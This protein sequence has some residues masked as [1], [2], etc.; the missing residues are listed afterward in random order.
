MLSSSSSSSPTS[1]RVWGI[2]HASA[3]VPVPK[4]ECFNH[5]GGTPHPS[6]QAFPAEAE[7]QECNPPGRAASEM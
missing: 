7:A 5:A 6:G 2:C 3:G 1:E 4:Q